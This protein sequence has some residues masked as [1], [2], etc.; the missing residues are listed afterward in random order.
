MKEFRKGLVRVGALKLVRKRHFKGTVKGSAMNVAGVGAAKTSLPEESRD[1]P[2]P[3]KASR[4]HHRSFGPARIAQFGPSCSYPWHFGEAQKGRAR[5]FVEPI[6][7]L[8]VSPGSLI[9]I[10]IAIEMPLPNGMF[11]KL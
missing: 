1:R 2:N 3:K 4:L 7:F 11:W 9:E 6:I 10:S 8:T 5:C